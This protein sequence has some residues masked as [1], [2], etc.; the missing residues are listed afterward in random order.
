[1]R[2][3]EAVEFVAD[4]AR[5][6]PDAPPIDVE[7]EDAIEVPREVDDDPAADDL[8]GQGRARAAGHEAD[9]TLGREAY[10]RADVG[11]GPRDR[12]GQGP[13]LVLRGV[14]RVDRPREV[15][16]EQV[17]L[18]RVRESFQIGDVHADGILGS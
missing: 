16:D 12:D 9:A 11:L 1:V 2:R 8:P 7:R 5:L 10:E 6:H 15:I 13:L 4:D 14:G 3:E 18:E 17:A